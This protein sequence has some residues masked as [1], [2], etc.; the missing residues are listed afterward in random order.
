[1][2]TTQRHS[3]PSLLD[4]A[5]QAPSAHPARR[6]VGSSVWL[7]SV[8]R[9]MAIWV[10]AFLV[11]LAAVALTLHASL[12]HLAALA[13]Y[14]LLGGVASMMVAA[15]ALWVTNDARMAG[16]RFKFALPVLLTALIL[17]LNVLL[18]ARQMFL[19]T[20]DTLLVL[21]ILIFGVLVAVPLSGTIGASIA[22]A[23]RR[24]EQGARRMAEGDYSIRVPERELGGAT[25][26]ARLGRWFN[27]MAASVEDAFARQ[28]R[29]ERERR[30]LV[31]AISHDL[32]TPLASV[33]AMS[34]A[35]SDGV[36]S[37]S[38]TVARY[39]RTIL[40]EVR[41]LSLLIDD[42]FELSRLEA[43]SPRELGL[44]R[45]PV[46]LEDVISDT[47]EALREQATS[48]GVAL[49][50]RVADELPPVSVDVRQVH[51]VL[52][53]LT[54]N[55]LRHTP[56]RGRVI[57]HAQPHEG[58]ILVRVV[59]S[60]EGI[61][62]HDLPHIFEPT[63]RGEASRQRERGAVGDVTAPGEPLARGA[64]LGLT[65]ARGLVAAHGG[66][67]W[68]ES[69]LTS[70]LAALLSDDATSDSAGAGSGPGACVSFTLP[71][72]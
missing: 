16:V 24:M 58:G 60:G 34:E 72:G 68:A 55:A 64:G 65:I 36:V 4:D 32:R 23:L 66:R 5:Q 28:E 37:D 26:L 9:W 11:T 50:G 53:N 71:L 35:I 21:D 46:A 7:E 3:A 44:H 31:A 43:G 13:A 52:A 18:V 40:M 19:S 56:A 69:P 25:E 59:D 41:H 27:Q 12:S 1:M 30:R 38:A 62:A 10:L 49:A 29:A 61:A 22:A 6:R 51:R 63:Y 70:A 20:D 39:Q 8:A 54:Q 45:E 67:M 57:I 15:G 47:L 2:L 42:L 14:L 33:R 17:S 48:R